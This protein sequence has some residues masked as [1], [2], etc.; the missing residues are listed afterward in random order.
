MPPS[1]SHAVS[2]TAD[3]SVSAGDVQYVQLGPTLVRQP[4]G[5]RHKQLTL[6]RDIRREPAISGRYSA[7]RERRC[8]GIIWA[9]E[10]ALGMMDREHRTRRL[11]R[12][13]F[14]DSPPQHL[15]QQAVAL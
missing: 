8:C 1:R 13:L 5:E 9:D 15:R 12:D 2:A 4:R 11:P 7:F 3:A 10:L 6:R 14:A